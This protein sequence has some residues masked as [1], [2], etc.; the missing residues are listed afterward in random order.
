M[1]ELL[2]CFLTFIFFVCFVMC[3]V[4]LSGIRSDTAKI[5]RYLDIM[6]RKMK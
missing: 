2:W 1:T 4:Y 3:T 6:N 5:I